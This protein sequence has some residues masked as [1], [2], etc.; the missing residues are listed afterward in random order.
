MI[1]QFYGKKWILD[2]NMATEITKSARRLISEDRSPF[3]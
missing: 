2:L 1:E 3:H